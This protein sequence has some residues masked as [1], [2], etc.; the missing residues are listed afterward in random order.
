MCEKQKYLHKQVGKPSGGTLSAI[1]EMQGASIFGIKF[2]HPF[3]KTAKNEGISVD[4]V[5]NKRT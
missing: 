4:V 2:C 1:P 5:E 3:A